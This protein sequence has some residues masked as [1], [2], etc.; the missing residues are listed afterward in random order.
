MMMNYNNCVLPNCYPPYRTKY[1]RMMQARGSKFCQPSGMLVCDANGNLVMTN[2]GVQNV[3]EGY[4]R[5]RRPVRQM[6]RR[7]VKERFHHGKDEIIFYSMESCPFCVR[8]AEA[9]KEE[10]K[11]GL[12][13]VKDA[14]E[15]P[16]G[17]K[18]FPTFVHAS[19]GK[20]T[21]GAV[22]NFQELKQKLK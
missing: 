13:V 19:S 8:S 15:A 16:P 7:P 17:V 4:Q 1:D 18:G 5:R 6:R 22:K 12:V 2:N 20:T 11:K 3:V 14:K 21:S 10:I 9:L